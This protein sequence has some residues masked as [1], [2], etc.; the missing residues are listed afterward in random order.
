VASGHRTS[1]SDCGSLQGWP[2]PAAR[3]WKDTPGMA[4]TGTNPDGSQ[5]TRLDHLPRVAGMAGW[6]TPTTES[7][8][9][10]LEAVA[11][12]A[13]GTRGEHGLDLGA[14]A[15]MACPMRLT[16]DGRLLTGSTAETASGG[17]LSPAHSRWLMGYPQEWDDCAPTATPSSRKSR[18]K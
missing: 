2:T 13:A 16:A 17:Q 8:E 6:P 1:A 15:M 3:D 10:S 7:K 5:R 18:R 4:T 14:A 9:W 11:K 12:Y